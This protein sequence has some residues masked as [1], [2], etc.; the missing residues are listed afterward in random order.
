MIF[1]FDDGYKVETKP[2]PPYGVRARLFDPNGKLVRQR[3]FKPGEAYD[4]EHHMAE[5][6]YVQHK[7]EGGE[8]KFV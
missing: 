1:D 2:N 3:V 5:T 6:I 4:E 7:I 8:W